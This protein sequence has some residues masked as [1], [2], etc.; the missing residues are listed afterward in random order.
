MEISANFILDTPSEMPKMTCFYVPACQHGH[1]TGISWETDMD[2]PRNGFFFRHVRFLG[3]GAPSPSNAACVN[4]KPL[5]SSKK[6]TTDLGTPGCLAKTIIESM[7]KSN[8]LFPTMNLH[9]KNQNLASG[10]VYP[11]WPLS[12]MSRKT[13]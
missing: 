13:F 6:R 2:D 10:F 4:Q 7:D 3:C 11:S 5:N 12:S 9:F 8:S 1:C